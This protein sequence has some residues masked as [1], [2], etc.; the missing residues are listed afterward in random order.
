MP[1]IAGSTRA[2]T[3]C[4]AT[5]ASKALPPASS[6]STAAAVACAFMELTAYS[7]PRMTGRTVRKSG[8]VRIVAEPAPSC[9]AARWSGK[10]SA[11]R[12]VTP[13]A[14]R[15]AAIVASFGR[16]ACPPSL[17]RCRPRCR[18]SIDAVAARRRPRVVRPYRSWPRTGPACTAAVH[19][20][21]IQT[22]RRVTAPRRAPPPGCSRVRSSLRDTR[23]RRATRRDSSSESTR[24]T[25]SRT[26]SDRSR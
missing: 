18:A 13:S 14:R 10:P 3:A 5:A 12:T 17:L 8:V 24:S 9:C 2:S 15:L 6:I 16:F 20:T 22:R 21:R 23:T 25:V 19:A 11:K 1:F 7:C 4:P 26:P